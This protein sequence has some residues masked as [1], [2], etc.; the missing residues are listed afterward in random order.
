[1]TKRGATVTKTRK[2]KGGGA[3]VGDGGDG[4]GRGVNRFGWTSGS[5]ANTPSK[6]KRATPVKDKVNMCIL[7]KYDPL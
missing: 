2:D 7:W 6:G 5:R 4:D 1:M 3:S